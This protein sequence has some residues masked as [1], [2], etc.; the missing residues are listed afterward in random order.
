[1]NRRE[2]IGCFA[3]CFTAACTYR[4]EQPPGTVIL[5][6][7]LQNELLQIGESK[8][9]AVIGV[10]VQRIATGN[11]PSSFRCLSMICTHARCN[12]VYQQQ[13]NEFHCPCHQSKFDGSGTVL[14]GPAN[15][16]LPQVPFRI[17]N[18]RLIVTG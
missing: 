2:F 9:N 8:Q 16:P 18:H 14:N 1:M 13:S 4:V 11:L 6:V 10:W 12:T 3:V 15:A 17:Q 5:E 7:D